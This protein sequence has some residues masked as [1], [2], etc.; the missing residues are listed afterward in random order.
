LGQTVDGGCSNFYT[1]ALMP[2]DETPTQAPPS[3][4]PKAGADGRDIRESPAQTFPVVAIGASAGGLQALEQLLGRLG[5]SGLALLVVQHFPA[6]Q[7]SNLPQLLSRACSLPVLSMA[8]GLPLLP[9]TVYVAPP[10]MA[11]NI[12]DNTLKLRQ[13]DGDGH[14]PHLPIDLLFRSLA[15]ERGPLAMAVVL[16]GAGTDGSLGIRAIKEVGGIT[17]V[18]DP[19]SAAHDG[20]PQAALATGMIDFCL[21]PEA[22]AEE[23]M[24]LGSHSY[25]LQTRFRRR[26]TEEFLTRL[27]EQ[28]HKVSGVDFSHYKLSTCSAASS[29]VWPCSAS[30]ARRT[31]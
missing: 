9:D 13:L 31:T 5:R 18:Q 2:S 29:D 17:M 6:E 26:F 23:L 3:G 10:G 1:G 16:S 21:P 25:A 8:D 11:V 12:A 15:K 30:I 20:M 14:R 19:A 4:D 27:F 7:R 28:L 24:R 22:I